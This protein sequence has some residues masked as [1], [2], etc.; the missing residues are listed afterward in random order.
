MR[1]DIMIHST[2]IH[3]YS[4]FLFYFISQGTLYVLESS[5]PG[6]MRTMMDIHYGKFVGI[7]VLCPGSDHCVVNIL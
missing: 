1:S 5:D 3:M 2:F 7:G 6:I 4:T